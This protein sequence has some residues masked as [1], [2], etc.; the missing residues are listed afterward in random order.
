MAVATAWTRKDLLRRHRVVI[1]KF[2]YDNLD[3]SITC[4]TGL[5]KIYGYSCSA[6]SVATK[7]V[8]RGVVAGGTITLTVTDPAAPCYLTV[9]AI[10]I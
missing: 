2:T 9:T 1:K 4:A 8:T 3:T 5:K 6:P 7:Y 10:G